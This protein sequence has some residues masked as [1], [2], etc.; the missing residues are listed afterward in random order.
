MACVPV[1]DDVLGERMCA[2]V[3]LKPG[4]GLT[5]QQ[6][7][8]HVSS[9]EIAK[10][11]LPEFLRIYPE[12]PVSPVGKVSKKDLVEDLRRQVVAE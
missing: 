12:F 5:L 7:V 1:D 8:D 2:C 10:H 6:L 3:V 4:A 9:F 11:K